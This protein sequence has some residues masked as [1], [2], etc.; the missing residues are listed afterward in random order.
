MADLNSFEFG[1]TQTTSPYPSDLWHHFRRLN[2]RTF[3]P[4]KFAALQAKRATFDRH[5][6]I[7][8]HIP[9]CAGISVVKSLFGD[10]DCGHT[11]L[12]RYQ[13]MFAPEEFR[14]YFKF[15]FVRNPFDRLVS[16]YFFMQKGGINEKDR[17][18]AQRKLA[19]F[20]SFEAFV[21]NWVT[22]FNVERALH[23][24]PQTRFICLDNRPPAMDFVGYLENIEADFAFVARKLG[25]NARLLETNRNAARERDYRQYYNDETRKIVA[26]V[27]ANDFK[28]LG[29]TFDNADLPTRLA[30]R[31]PDGRLTGQ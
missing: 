7:F 14:R 16:A 12:L 18:W 28:M 4:A 5:Q 2:F 6:C 31:G 23:F 15:T 20:D 3:R 19:R 9:K 13:I 21:K 30:Q 8:V 25:L 10:F 11:S 22:P 17:R 26:R 24:R 1:M 29:Y 27:Y